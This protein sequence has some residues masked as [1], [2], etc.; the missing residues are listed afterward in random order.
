MQP[1]RQTYKEMLSIIKALEVQERRLESKIGE[2]V[3]DQY[4]FK[5]NTFYYVNEARIIY[6]E[7]VEVRGNKKY[8]LALINLIYKKPNKRNKK[9]RKRL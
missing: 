2:L 5:D 9:K 4:L 7:L 1:R 6:K 8:Y 3:E